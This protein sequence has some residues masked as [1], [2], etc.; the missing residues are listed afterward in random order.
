M[1]ASRKYSLL[2]RVKDDSNNEIGTVSGFFTDKNGE[3]YAIVCLD[4]QYRLNS[5]QWCSSDTE[6]TNMP[7][8]YK[9]EENI[10]KTTETATESCNLI[11]SYCST[12]NYTSTA[13][14]HCRSKSFVIEGITYYGQLPN[15][16]E[17]MDIYKYK[18]ELTTLDP[19]SETYT[20]VSVGYKNTWTCL[21]CTASVA[22]FMNANGGTYGS[23]SSSNKALTTL[24][25]L[26]ILE[27][28]N[29]RGSSGTTTTEYLE[30]IDDAFKAIKTSIISKGQIPSGDITTY[31]TAINAIP[32]LTTIP[33]DTW[34]EYVMYDYSNESNTSKYYEMLATNEFPSSGWSSG[35]FRNIR[36]IS[37]AG[38]YFL[39][40]NG[41]TYNN[42]RFDNL[43]QIGYNTTTSAG[44]YFMGY[45]SGLTLTFPELTNMRTSNYGFSY[46]SNCNYTFSKL[47]TFNSSYSFSYSNTNCSFS[48]PALSTVTGSYA[49][50]SN[51][52]CSYSFP[53][54]TTVS[55]SY[56]CSSNT[57]CSFS[58]PALTTI[59][60]SDFCR[61][62]PNYTYSFP[63]LTTI[64]G[65]Y[66]FYSNT[67]CSYS[68]PALST[69]T[70]SYFLNNYN[71]ILTVNL[72]KITYISCCYPTNV[73]TN[74]ITWNLTNSGPV[75]FGTIP[76]NT[77]ASK[78]SIEIN[79]KNA[80][81]LFFIM[82][83]ASAASGYTGYST[84][85]ITP[86][87]NNYNMNTSTTYFCR[88]LGPG[89]VSLVQP[90]L[91][92][93]KDITKDYA[94]NNCS[95]TELTLPQVTTIT[96]R[97]ILGSSTSM[98][99]LNLPKCNSIT[100]KYA[101]SSSSLTEIHFASSN[102]TA[103]EASTGY[104]TKWGRSAMTIYFD[105]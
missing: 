61:N 13:V 71:G 103:I 3:N 25:A 37:Q 93:L 92:K 77:N 27:L 91:N 74:K 54:L 90:L 43:K 68:F 94:F 21:Q 96:S 16:K 31:A 41:Q 6:V 102:K 98:V 88:Y 45:R 42:I 87:T 30:D 18:S 2:Q 39:G 101:F 53:A 36:Y 48:F 12:N 32:V 11:L 81:S 85:T 60:G 44:T 97:Y 70:G 75:N 78:G 55:A 59:S 4:A 19:T 84:V 64:S 65:N 1:T 40:R 62:N 73:A 82:P 35:D 80:T 89:N 10:W 7:I 46:S 8:Y 79:V 34:N 22:W 52:N 20:T 29:P 5:S 99:K 56:F 15:V 23:T 69:V 105:L 49:F 33:F 24:M 28:P 104:S 17:L 76:V 26:P 14:S 50:Y 9:T 63:A 95:L 57:N 51:T 47:Q 67:N 86:P 100:N 83:S 72:P 58:F 66:A 38:N